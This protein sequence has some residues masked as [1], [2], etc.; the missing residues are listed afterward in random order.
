MSACI[1]DNRMKY[2]PN[3]HST[4][5]KEKLNQGPKDMPDRGGQKPN[6]QITATTVPLSRKENQVA[7][8]GRSPSHGVPN[9]DG[10][11]HV[12]LSRTAS[13][14]YE[15]AGGLSETTRQHSFLG[16]SRTKKA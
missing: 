13:S 1:A 14:P 6:A 15:K 9:F 2:P 7:Q 10:A 16:K 5:T 11:T 3:F 8:F 4:S 12:N